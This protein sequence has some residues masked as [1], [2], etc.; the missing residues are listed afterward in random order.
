ML[1]IT[2]FLCLV[3]FHSRQTSIWPEETVRFLESG[4]VLPLD[5]TLFGHFVSV[6]SRQTVVSWQLAGRSGAIFMNLDVFLIGVFVCLV[7]FYSWQT[8]IL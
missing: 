8:V 4:W 5:S 7:K 6:Y 2:V 1:F 3:K